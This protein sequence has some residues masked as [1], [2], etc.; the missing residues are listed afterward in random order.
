M[1]SVCVATYNSSRYI[2]EQIES[3]LSQIGET[4]EIIISDD[5]SKDDTIEKIKAVCDDRIK[6][7]TNEGTHGYTPN[8]ENAL[9]HAKGDYIF[10]SDHDDVWKE[11]KVKVCMQYLREYDYVVSDA[12]VTNEHLE[13]IYPSYFQQRIVYE[14]WLGNLYRFGYLGC[15]HA[16]R[17]EILKKALPFPTN[18]RYCTHDNW[19]YMIG[20]TFYRVKIIN[21]PLMYYRRHDGT[22]SNGGNNDHKPLLFRIAYRSYLLFN[23]VKRCCK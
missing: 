1:I 22:A 12:I 20:K 14:G 8:F 16:F 5:G 9:K 2:I 6:I 4:D 7:F 18:Y 19:L 10:L 15:L 23:L 11:N 13:P 21:E 3:I 17:K